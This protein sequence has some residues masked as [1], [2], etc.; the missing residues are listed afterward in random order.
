MKGMISWRVRPLR[1][2]LPGGNARLSWTLNKPLR[3]VEGCPSP[4]GIHPG[5]D[6]VG[7]FPRGG[8]RR[9]AAGPAPGFRLAKQPRRRSL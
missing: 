6:V 3:G 8:E 7:R 2:G 1:D 9:A 5:C 4:K